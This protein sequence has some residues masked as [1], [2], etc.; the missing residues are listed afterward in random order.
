MTEGVIPKAFVWRRLHSI[1]G[2]WLVLFLF[3][4][5][6]TN[7]QAA[8]WIGDDG[9]GFVNG[10]NFIH[11]LPYLQ[12]IE[13]TLLGV[14]FLVHGL[15][16]IKYLWT[17]KSNSFPSDG[18]KPALFKFSRNR[19]YTW[20]RWTSWILL[21]G[22]I[23]HVVQMRF[24]EYPTSVKVGSQENYIVRLSEDAGLPTLAQ[25]LD[26]KIYTPDE[27][28]S[29]QDEVAQAAKVVDVEN[30][31]DKQDL[32]QEKRFAKALEKKPLT[33]GEVAAVAK[34]FGTATL[35]IVRDTFKMPLMIALYSIFVVASCYHAFNGFWTSFITWGVTLT[36]RSQ[37]LFLRLCILLML[38]VIFLGLA[39][40]W[41]TYWVNLRN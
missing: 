27:A 20:Q 9:F 39:S 29:L 5:L 7:S 24:I 23:L 11:N 10:V 1:V 8:L 36:P 14:P 38:L 19:A 37:K 6:L 18:S 15:W 21:I 33:E 12:V 13:L 41:G 40:A 22:L 17:G 26:F 34:D 25:R 28:G 32:E 4:H 30:A 31:V 16:G 35:L 2:V 3:E